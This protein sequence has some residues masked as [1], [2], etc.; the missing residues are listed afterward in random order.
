MEKPTSYRLITR[1]TQKFLQAIFDKH[2]KN[3]I[4]CSLLLSHRICLCFRQL[5]VADW[6]V[7]PKESVN[8]LTKIAE[9]CQRFQQTVE[10]YMLNMFLCSKAGNY[11]L[12]AEVYCTKTVV[13]KEFYG[14]KVRF[15]QILARKSR[16][17]TAN[18]ANGE[19]RLE[20]LT[21]ISRAQWIEARWI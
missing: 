21:N 13:S 15:Q 6:T 14:P 18:E 9:M 4:W 2:P 8:F 3:F 10:F 7:L 5:L 19:F 20:I 16:K 1:S 12:L 17:I 11:L